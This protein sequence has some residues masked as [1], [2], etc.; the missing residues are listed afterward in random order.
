VSYS[1]DIEVA[2]FAVSHWPINHVS[3]IDEYGDPIPDYGNGSQF[4]PEDVHEEFVAISLV[5]PT[6]YSYGELSNLPYEEFVKLAALARAKRWTPATRN[7]HDKY[8]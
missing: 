7:K 4:L 6:G 5:E 2:C 1:N 8:L 3:F